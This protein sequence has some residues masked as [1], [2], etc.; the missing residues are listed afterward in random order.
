MQT[1]TMDSSIRDKV[2]GLRLG[3][4]HYDNVSLSATPKMLKGR[5]NLFLENIRHDYLDKPIT[6][7]PG[8][9]EWRRIFKAL[10][11][12]P[13]RYRP[14]SEA[15]VR[16]VL[17]NKPF[18]WIHTGVD[19]NNFL[20]LQFGLPAGL[21]DR[22]KIEGNVC[23]RLGKKS[24]TYKGLNGREISCEG[25][26]VLADEQGPF[27]SPFVDSIRTSVTEEAKRLAHVFYIYPEFNR[28]TDEQLLKSAG[29]MFTH[30]NGGACTKVDGKPYLV[31]T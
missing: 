30:V 10:G 26:L 29:E 21:Y 16:R 23:L 15:L 18:H 25:K 13:S 6:E 31:I 28:W 12:D 1:Y 22:D 5:I 11:I 8:I 24:E 9:T 4:L 20:S 19:I 27:G 3:I 2:P 14:S 17:Q 7:V